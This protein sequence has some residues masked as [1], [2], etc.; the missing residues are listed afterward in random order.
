MDDHVMGYFDDLGLHS[1]AVLP[2]CTAYLDRRFPGTWSLEYMHAGRMEMAID[3]GPSIVLDRPAAFWHLPEHR[4]RYGACDRRGWDH[5][6]LMFTGPRAA[7]L[8]GELQRVHPAGWCQVADPTVFQ[9]RMRVAIELVRR[10]D[11]VRHP[12]AVAAVEDLVARLVCA[13]RAG[14][15]IAAVIALAERMRQNPVRSWP[16]SVEARTLGLSEVHLRRI[17]RQITGLSP[18]GWCLA[19]RMQAA[20]R[21][22]ADG[23]AIASAASAAGYDDPAQFSRMFRRHYGTS[24]RRWRGVLPLGLGSRDRE[25]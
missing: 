19:A 10:G 22:L 21:A 2:A 20:V 4:Y 11:P 24:P 3:S 25:S 9:A 6:W 15:R 14:G 13:P 17:F 8:I 5:H 1:G 23:A 18:V 16:L 12:E 7:R